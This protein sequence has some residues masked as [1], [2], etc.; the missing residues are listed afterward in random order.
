MEL[1]QTYTR[2]NVY[3]W[4]I[5]VLYLMVNAAL[6]ALN[7]VKYDTG[8]FNIY[9][10]QGYCTNRIVCMYVEPYGQSLATTTHAS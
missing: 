8:R 4:V 9:T 10:V 5:L 1:D 3:S 7:F 2:S 6:F